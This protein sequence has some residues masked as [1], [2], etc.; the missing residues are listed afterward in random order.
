MISSKVGTREEL[1][2]LTIRPLLSD[3]DGSE[4]HIHWTPPSA[5]FDDQ[6][7]ADL[8]MALANELEQTNRD[9]QGT[10]ADAEGCRYLSC[11][12]THECDRVVATVVG[13]IGEFG[14]EE[15]VGEP[16]ERPGPAEHG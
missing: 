2:E 7:M 5:T 15:I 3:H 16:G 4:L 9:R 1:T 12:T 13:E 10:E 14:R 8:L 6:V 11:T